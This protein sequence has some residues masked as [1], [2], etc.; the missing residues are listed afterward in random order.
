MFFS[1]KVR[2]VYFDQCLGAVRSKHWSKY[3]FSCFLHEKCRKIQKARKL[4]QNYA[5][6][7]FLQLFGTALVEQ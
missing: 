1:L 3:A 5:K 7:M 6:N 2:V 4:C